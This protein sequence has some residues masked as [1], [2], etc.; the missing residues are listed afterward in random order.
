MRARL[1]THP[2]RLPAQV[3]GFD[4]AGSTVRTT[5]GGTVWN[6]TTGSD[7][8][9]RQALPS[10]PAGGPYTISFTSS[11]GG[12]LTMSDVLFGDVIVCGGQSNMQ[13]TVSSAFNASAEIAAA[14]YPNIRIFTVGD[15]TTSK[16]PLNDLA[17]VLQNWTAVTPASI[18][19]PEF[20]Y[21]SAICY[22]T[23]RCA[24]RHLQCQLA[25][26][27]HPP[28][29]VSAPSPRAA[30]CTTRWAAPCRSAS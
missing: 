17:T 14:N 9:W 25:L 13:F 15:G 2:P 6:A 18:G 8:I 28:A 26:L 5:F 20:S 1:H 3:W 7:G 23:G 10:T 21:F 24:R 4:T 27:P 30:M 22:F 19:G 11:A 29:L 16:V 12:S